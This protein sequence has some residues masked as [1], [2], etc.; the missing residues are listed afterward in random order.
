MDGIFGQVVVQILLIRKLE[1]EAVGH[2]FVEGLP[3]AV[4]A[5]SEGEH[6]RLAGGGRLEASGAE[7]E[8]GGEVPLERLPWDL[9]AVLEEHDVS[10]RWAV[11]DGGAGGRV[12]DAVAGVKDVSGGS[13][14]GIEKS[15]RTILALALSIALR[16]LSLKASTSHECAKCRTLV[17][18][19]CGGEGEGCHVRTD[20]MDGDSESLALERRLKVGRSSR[21]IDIGRRSPSDMVFLDISRAKLC[22]PVIVIVVVGDEASAYVKRGWTRPAS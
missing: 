16:C 10:V 15:T 13:E 20:L 21:A 14:T 6:V 9:C 2:A 11:H 5:R 12:H 3:R 17:G 19:D 4:L 7:S 8:E 22:M 18:E 1:H